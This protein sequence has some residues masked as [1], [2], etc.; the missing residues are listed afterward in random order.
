METTNALAALNT[1][2]D[3]DPEAMR[4]LF[5]TRVWCNEA[6]ADH[7][8]IQVRE[9]DGRFSV[10]VIGL[11]NGLFGVNPDTQ[12]GYIAA[13]YDDN[14]Q[15]TGF[16]RFEPAAEDSEPKVTAPKFED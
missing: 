5:G 14:N 4:Q 1:A 6:L 16:I 11:I 8:S 2:L 15:L 9:E 12:A 13:Q 10:G 3:L 7:P